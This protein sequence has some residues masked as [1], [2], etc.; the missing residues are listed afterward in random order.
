MWEK[1]EWGKGANVLGKTEGIIRPVDEWKICT[2]RE[3][4][5][6]SE[7]LQ[8]SSIIRNMKETERGREVVVYLN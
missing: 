7:T 3:W 5:K 6:G 4:V 2:G 1:R 8:T